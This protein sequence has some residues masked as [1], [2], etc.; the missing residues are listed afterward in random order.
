[1]TED[2]SYRSEYLLDLIKAVAEPTETILEIGEGDGRNVNFLKEKGYPHVEGIDKLNGTPIEL[3]EPKEYDVIYTM[4][5]LFLIPP[6]NEWV[7][8]KIANM[9]KKYIITIEGEKTATNGVFGR[10][11]SRVFAPFGYTQIYQED[12]VFNKYGVARILKKI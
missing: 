5:T 8:E 2:L 3:V 10:D 4:S 1:M 9:A 6:E 7:F 11:Y 12:R